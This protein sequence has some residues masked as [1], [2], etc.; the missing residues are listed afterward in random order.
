MTESQP[1]MKADGRRWGPRIATHRPSSVRFICSAIV[2]LVFAGGLSGQPSLAA[3]K[4][5]AP[6]KAIPIAKVGKKVE[7]DRDILPFFRES[8]LACHNRTTTKAGVILET[9]EDILKGGDNGKIAT[10]KRGSSSLL[11][12]VSAHQTDP[13][14]PPVGNKAS[15]PNLTPDQLGLLKAWIDQ[16]AKGEVRRE[17]A[18]DWQPLPAGLNPIYAVAVSPDGQF[19]ACGR[20]NQIH[21][22]HLPTGRLVERLH[23]PAL[24]QS[25]LYPKR[26]VAHRDMVYSLAFSPDGSLLASGSYREVKLW[27]RPVHPELF[28]L[29]FE[30]R[31]KALCATLSPDGQ[32]LVAGHADGKLRITD[33]ESGK[34]RKTVALH[35]GAVTVLQF[36]PDG[37][38]LASAG[39]DRQLLVL[40]AD[41]WKETFQAT[42]TETVTALAWLGDNSHL[43][44]GGPDKAI[45]VWALPGSPVISTNVPHAVATNA[46]AA[47]AG[48]G[49][50][51]ERE[52][53]G[54]EGA[55]TALAA[56]QSAGHQVWSGAADGKVQL[57]DLA[58]GESVRTIEHGGLVTSVA[59][60][61]DG[62]TIASTGTNGLVKLWQTTDG[63]LVA[64]MKGDHFARGEAA[65][66]ERGAA[67][68]AAD[69]EYRKQVITDAE[70][71]SKTQEERLKKA[72]EDLA[73][74]DK[75]AGEKQKALNDAAAAK[76]AAERELA[77]IESPLKKVQA[78]FDAATRAKVETATAL[79]AAKE[80]TT[81]ADQALAA[82]LETELTGRTKA[83]ADAKIILD[84]VEA[85][86][87]PKQ[88]PAIDKV[89]NAEKARAAAEGEFQ[90]SERE[91]SIA[92]NEHQLATRAAKEATDKVESA[93]AALATS[94]QARSAADAAVAAA[95]Q[96][97]LASEQPVT[98]AAFLDNGITLTTAGASRRIQSWGATNGA[99]FAIYHG[100]TNA[101]LSLASTRNGR[102]ASLDAGGA[103]KLWNLH[104]EWKLARSLGTGEA[105][106]PLVDRVTALS[107]SPDGT[108]LA[109]GGGE[110]SREGELKL[111]TVPD[112]VLTNQFRGVHS[113]V[114][115]ALAFSPDGK[116]LASGSA[117]RFMKVVD[118]KKGSLLKTFEGHTHHVYGVDWKADGRTL[119]SAGGDKSVKVW[120]FVS[121][122]RRKNIEGY[123]KEV[124]AVKFLGISD[125]M[126]TTAGDN[127]VRVVKEDGGEV[128]NLTTG[129][130]MQACAVTPDG[131]VIVAGGQDSVLWIW[132][133][134]NK[135]PM[136]FKPDPAPAADPKLAQQSK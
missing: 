6:A 28:T 49:L 107:F 86:L 132:T 83:E 98:A 102:L 70:K 11:L 108:L 1:L 111:W 82:T 20:A 136:R 56:A 15:A 42:A 134:L 26:G 81:E 17:V 36:S 95:K 78:E 25:G 110:P 39:E 133:D 114:V 80:K 85:G 91:K 77:D 14:M 51:L 23:D 87:K 67:V 59:L 45:R 64:E 71:E 104:Q 100:H 31:E 46:P 60:R 37:E 113:D 123:G 55:V 127:R 118:V 44:T 5:E 130:Y 47:K 30:E 109:S 92:T 75:T 34:L 8:C 32:W 124:T 101:I 27:Q 125:Q 38:W 65:A 33:T 126:V 129:D 57:W 58:K 122:E 21:V 99:A 63:K 73:A 35:K 10:P 116:L 88:Q 16:G 117:D 106:S 2:G 9:P 12:K 103:V 94:E 43:A 105:G 131:K 121:G 135:E 48:Q 53:K 66:R 62:Q 119:A 13:L 97:A 84:L 68:A 74:K 76:A 4:A 93:K 54:H 40:S 24:Q 90:K 3:E 79:K 72:T 69:V 29:Q 41:K 96:L 120:D 7:F 128:K 115:L 18:I 89:T 19:A 112:G 61:P 50:V 22:Y 52:L